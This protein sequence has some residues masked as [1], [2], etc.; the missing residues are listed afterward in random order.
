VVKPVLVRVVEPDSATNARHGA[1]HRRT[2][3]TAAVLGLSAVQYDILRV[4][5]YIERVAP[6]HTLLIPGRGINRLFCQYHHCTY[7]QYNPQERGYVPCCAHVCPEIPPR[8]ES[9]DQFLPNL[10]LPPSNMYVVALSSGP[11]GPYQP[12]DYKSANNKIVCDFSILN[13]YNSLMGNYTL[14]M[15]KVIVSANKSI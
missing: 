8:T 3:H 9:H 6:L 15:R 10:L 14:K 1:V 13:M 4:Q 7:P 12:R 2:A 11:L 5:R